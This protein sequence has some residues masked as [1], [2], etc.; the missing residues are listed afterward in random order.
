MLKSSSEER[1]EMR[2]CETRKSASYRLVTEVSA[3]V[4][5]PDDISRLSQHLGPQNNARQI[6]RVLS[7]IYTR[8]GTT[9]PAALQCRISDIRAKSPSPDRSPRDVWRN[10]P[11]SSKLLEQAY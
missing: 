6:L 9:S 5:S 8:A 7:R 10:E 4:C 11:R 2:V 3:A 1:I